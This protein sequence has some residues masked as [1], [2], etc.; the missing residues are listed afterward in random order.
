MT[1]RNILSESLDIGPCAVGIGFFDG[2][3]LGHQRLI[4]EL[5]A[6]GKRVGLPAVIFTFDHSPRK[7]LSPDIFKG[8]ITSP[9]EKFSY[10]LNLGVDHVV[11]RPFE[12]DFSKLSHKEFIQEILLDRLNARAV[13]VGFNFHFGADKHGDAKYL[14]R[15]L[16]NHSC[17][18]HIIDKVTHQGEVVSSSIIRQAIEAGDFERAN[19]FLGR[20]ASLVGEVVS[21]D[22]RG[23]ELGFPTANICLKSTNKILPP[24]GVYVCYADTPR[25]TFPALVNIGT[26]PTFNKKNLLLEAHLIDFTDSLYHQSIRIRFK[27]RLREEIKFPSAE[28]LIEQITK[29]QQEAKAILKLG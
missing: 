3:H 27:K 13:F 2:V 15:K 4:S 14:Q 16:L 26:R 23:R 12:L 22:S 25:G 5:I 6:Y 7:L 1:I 24:K 21:G 28:A 9:E 29:D 18:C 11:F 8:Y 20:E 10:L 17:E 19:M